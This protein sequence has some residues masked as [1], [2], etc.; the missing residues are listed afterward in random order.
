[1]Y[2]HLTKSELTTL[3]DKLQASLTARLTEP[4]EAA[5]ANRSVKY[6]VRVQ[7]IRRELDAVLAEL[8]RR[9]GAAPVRRPIYI[10]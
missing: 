5:G 9:E 2:G 10:V 3:R 6:A 8:G 1:M 7:D 4:T